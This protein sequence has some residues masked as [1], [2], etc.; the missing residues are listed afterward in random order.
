MP[1][2]METVSEKILDPWFHYLSVIILVP[3]GTITIGRYL[4]IIVIS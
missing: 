1:P 2:N 4:F 3:I